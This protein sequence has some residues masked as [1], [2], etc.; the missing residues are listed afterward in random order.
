[1]S[2][3]Q[4]DTH[5]TDGLTLYT[6]EQAKVPITWDHNVASI[7][8]TLLSVG[9]AL[10]T[11]YPELHHLIVTNTVEERGITYID[12]PTKIDQGVR[13]SMRHE[14]LALGY[15]QTSFHYYSVSCVFSIAGAMASAEFS[16]RDLLIIRHEA[17]D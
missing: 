16:D 4:D 2:L 1:M 14:S 7:T 8:G 17:L 5:Q 9:R 3:D 12:D 6:D 10:R 15:Y 11:Q 13:L